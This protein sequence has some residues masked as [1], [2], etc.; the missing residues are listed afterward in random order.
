M[1]PLYTTSQV[2]EVDDF[3]INKLKM[4]GIILMENA[5]LQIYH[6]II[7]ELELLPGEVKI[8]IVCGKG[9]NG[10][11]GF[12]VARH[13]LINNFEVA[14]VHIGNPDEMSDDC[15]IN[16]NILINLSSAN[17]KLVLK[18]Y[19]APKDLKVFQDSFVVID[20]L[21]GS[22]MEGDLRDPYLTIVNRL[23]ELNAFKVAVDIPTGLNADKGSADNAFISDLTIT[24]GELKKGLFFGDGKKFAGKT[25]KGS[26]GID[27]SFFD[28]F[29][30][31]EYLIEPED[32]FLSLPAKDN[33]ANKYSAGKVFTIAGSGELPGAASMTAAS[34][35]KVGAGSSILAFP[36]SVKNLAHLLSTEVIV[37]SY[38]DDGAE[39][40]S[41]RNVDELNPRLEWA[42]VL[43]IGP[44]LG[45]NN[46]TI[47]AV[48]SIIS[49]RKSKNIV[50]DADAIYALSQ[51]NYKSINLNGVII[52]PHHGEFSNLLGIETS[53]LKKDLLK[54]GKEFVSQTGSY[55]VLKGAPTLIF[56]PEEEVLIN[57]TGNPGMAKFGTGDV[58]TGIIAGILSQQKDIEKALISAVYLHSLAADLLLKEKTEYGYTA[59]DI[60]NNL[61][62]AIKFLRSSFV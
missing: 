13:F 17:K 39:F 60:M 16:Y 2:R 58:L 50:I 21:L 3:A 5:S 36:E 15:K 45:R 28:K 48:V 33:N 19:S 47:D 30:P 37:K 27:V 40:L 44:G 35:F 18:K 20:A 62:S 9:N 59:T 51:R 12:A 25:V 61:P 53:Q 10:G 24:L 43:A 7:E 54:Y 49:Q 4:P 38:K 57:T 1:I 55:L 22:G 8:G 14:V 56:T 26:I 32:V 52:T 46:E 34:A 6:K 29:Y 41:A 11:D 23:N 42:D 31:Q